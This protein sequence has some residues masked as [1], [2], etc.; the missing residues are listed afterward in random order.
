MP[1]THT[2]ITKDSLIGTWSLISYFAEAPDPQ[3][4]DAPT[5]Y[6]M[7]PDARG[8]LVYTTDGQMTVSV[9][10]KVTKK[11]WENPND[12]VMYAGRYWIEDSNSDDDDGDEDEKQQPGGVPIVHH[13]VE[14]ASSVEFEGSQKREAMI[15]P[16]G[17]LRLSGL[18][19]L[20][21]GMEQKMKPVLV[22]ER[23]SR[24]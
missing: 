13:E 20:E 11:A 6:P 22:W 8:T 7:G 4:D 2:P 18:R 12:G 16:E 19:L 14:M 24:A 10:P 15:S 17:R 1:Q 5:H 9:L 23:I 3:D 21:V